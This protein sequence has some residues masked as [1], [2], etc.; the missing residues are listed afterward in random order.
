MPEKMEKIAVRE[1]MGDMVH[2]VKDPIDQANSMAESLLDREIDKGQ[3]EKFREKLIKYVNIVN[4]MAY[5]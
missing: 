4:T 1:V 3:Y 5:L 2:T